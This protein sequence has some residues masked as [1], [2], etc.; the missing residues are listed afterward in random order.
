MLMTCDY[1]GKEL[2]D[3]ISPPGRGVFC[4]EKCLKADTDRWVGI[5]VLAYRYGIDADELA[6]LLSKIKD[7]QS[8]EGEDFEFTKGPKMKR[9][10]RT[11]D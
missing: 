5:G 6:A 10:D 9:K 1:C 11:D 2:R 7:G 8:L 4:N 3:L